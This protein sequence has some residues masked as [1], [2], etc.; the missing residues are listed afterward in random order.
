MYDTTPMA[1]REQAGRSPLWGL[2]RIRGDSMLPT[3]RDGDR[4]LIRYGVRPRPG[5]LVLARFP[6]GTLVVKRATEPRPDRADR[7]AWWLLSDN[8]AAGVDSRHR[9]PIRSV[10]G[11]VRARIWPW[12]GIRLGC[13][14]LA[15]GS[16]NE[17]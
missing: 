13:A 14:R 2:A 11:V 8:P 4:V 7:E 17:T 9:G 3:L 16:D 5:Q 15:P 1:G 6:D 12:P 10:V